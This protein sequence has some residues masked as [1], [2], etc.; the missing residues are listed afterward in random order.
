MNAYKI[1]RMTFD[2]D[3]ML[4]KEDCEKI[5][6]DILSLGYS[7]FN[8]T[9][10]FV[11][12]KSER[13]GLRDLDLLIGDKNTVDRLLE[14]GR[15]VSIAGEKFVVPSAV[16]LIEMKLHAMSG[17]KKREI[18]DLPDVIQLLAVNNI[19]QESGDIKKLFVKYSAMELYERIVKAL[20]PDKG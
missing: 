17:N 6:P 3:F 12:Y 18:K 20:K 11:Q 5:E 15:E 1:Q 4:T 16:H 7:I 8:R 14:Q 2:V 10:A 19:D 13:A 9:A